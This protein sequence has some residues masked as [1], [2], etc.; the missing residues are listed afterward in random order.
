MQ[1][2]ISKKTDRNSLCCIRVDGSYTRSDTGPSLPHHDLEHFVVESALG[3]KNGFY[4]MVSQRYSIQQLSDKDVIKKLGQESWQAE[5]VTRALQSFSGGA[6]TADQ[7]AALVATELNQTGEELQH[8]L[9][10][11]AAEKMKADFLKLLNTWQE[12]PDGESLEL[13]FGS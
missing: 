3:L 4:G 6:C 9:S 5:I 2:R 7:F 1:I 11:Q 8:D 12:I 10:P 13:S